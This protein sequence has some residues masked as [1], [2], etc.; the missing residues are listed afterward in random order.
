MEKNLEMLF[1]LSRDPMLA[2]EAGKIVYANT[3][4]HVAFPGLAAAGRSGAEIVP[5]QL[6]S[7]TS[8]HFV[9]S[10]AVAGKQ[11]TVSAARLGETQVL[12]FVS[13]TAVQ[14][15]GLVSDGLMTNLLSAM[16]NAGFAARRVSSMLEEGGDPEQFLAILQ[17]NHSS[18]LRQLT[19]L[20]FAIHL[21]DNNAYCAPRRTELVEFCSNLAATVGVLTR[22]RGAKLEFSSPLP[23]LWAP[24]DPELLERLL[25]N[26]LS[27]SLAHTPSEGLIRLR[28]AKSGQNAVLSVDDNGEGISPEILLNIFARYE[29]RLDGAHLDRAVTA[30][31]GLGVASGIARLHGGTLIIESRE[32]KGT[33]VRAMLPL[34]ASAT[35]V[36]ESGSPAPR[37]MDRILME[38]ADFLGPDFYRSNYLD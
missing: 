26:L 19:N 30:G 4:A 1:E 15:S 11:Y 7:D 29:C 13:R 17:H 3:A 10:A 12:S 23:E 21:R 25:L 37:G 22:G 36:L 16:C 5:A 8:E 34:S 9:A 14:S 28:V 20:D 18:L 38:L 35:E 24:A 33:S 32:G 6:L 31:L 27:N 2:V